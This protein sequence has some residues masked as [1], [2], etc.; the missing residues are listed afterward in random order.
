MTALVDD[1]EIKPSLAQISLEDLISSPDI[2]T[3]DNT[4]I[5]KYLRYNLLLQILNLRP[6]LLNLPI[7][8]L[9][10]RFNLRPFQLLLRSIQFLLLSLPL[11]LTLADKK[12][13]TSLNNIIDNPSRIA[14]AD[15]VNPTADSLDD[16]IDC[17]VRG[18]A[19]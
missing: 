7:K 13:Q 18:C 2:S 11:P 5:L 3:A 16:V 12:I 4:S 9:P 1:H 17:D 15:T 8:F 6:Y 19:G 10:L 14:Y